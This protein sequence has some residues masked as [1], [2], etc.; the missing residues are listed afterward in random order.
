MKRIQYSRLANRTERCRQVG[1]EYQY[2][3]VC[4][5]ESS[6]L[7]RGTVWMAKDQLN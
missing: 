4:S 7:V 5:E 2:G 1:V 3:S 6:V